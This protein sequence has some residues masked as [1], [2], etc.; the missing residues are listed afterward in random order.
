MQTLPTSRIHLAIVDSVVLV[1]LKRQI[2]ENLS[3]GH[4][5]YG[6]PCDHLHGDCHG[7]FSNEGVGLWNGIIIWCFNSALELVVEVTSNMMELVE[8]TGELKLIHFQAC[9]L[10]T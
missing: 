2:L 3:N 1:P 5:V 9:T 7:C 4:C 8:G 6:A 10:S